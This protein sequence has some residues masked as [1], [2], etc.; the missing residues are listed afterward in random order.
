MLGFIIGLIIGGVVGM[1]A[2]CL[3]VAAGHADKRKNCTGSEK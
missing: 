2:M 3:C 1:F